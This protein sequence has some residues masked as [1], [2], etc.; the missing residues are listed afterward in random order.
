MLTHPTPYH[1]KHCNQRQV[2]KGLIYAQSFQ[3]LKE[4][5]KQM[6][7]TYKTIPTKKEMVKTK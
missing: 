3:L 6:N 4:K 2:N 7:Q 5:T 1:V